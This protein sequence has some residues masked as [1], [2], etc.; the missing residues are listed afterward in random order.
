MSAVWNKTV[1][2]RGGVKWLKENYA[3]T[4]NSEIKAK[5]GISKGVL[6]RLVREYGLR[7]SPEY[8]KAVNRESRRLA[9]KAAMAKGWPPKGYVIPKS[10][11]ARKKGLEKMTEMRA[12]AEF[13][14][15]WRKNISDTR[16][17]LYKDEKRRVLF[18]LEQKTDIKVVSASHAKRC[19]RLKLRKLGYIIG[20]GESIAYW[21]AETK[22]NE[23]KERTAQKHGIRIMPCS[24]AQ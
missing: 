7:K 16:K 4:P 1:L 22:R 6:D 11:E 13:N 12:D 10:D 18:G 14:A 20:R 21:N 24:E 17:K 5:F 2:P 19:C 23:S 8:L 15:R 9:V 3:N